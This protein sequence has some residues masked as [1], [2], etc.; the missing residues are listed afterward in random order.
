MCIKTIKNSWNMF[1][2]CLSDSKNLRELRVKIQKSFEFLIGFSS[3]I[4]ENFFLLYVYLLFLTYRVQRFEDQ[5]FFNWQIISHVQ[6]FRLTDGTTKFSRLKNKNIYEKK[7][8]IFLSN[9]KK[10]EKKWHIIN[11]TEYK[12]S[13]RI[14]VG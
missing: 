6:R 12:K 10:L 8:L 7:E 11:K 3:H 13:T 1:N 5:F 2:H 9:I 4:N 14:L